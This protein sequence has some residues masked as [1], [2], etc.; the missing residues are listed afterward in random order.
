M[1]LSP[2]PEPAPSAFAKLAAQ[3]PL[4]A[5][6]AAPELKPT[7]KLTAFTQQQPILITYGARLHTHPCI[8]IATVVLPIAYRSRSRRQITATRWLQHSSVRL[9]SRLWLRKYGA[10]AQRSRRNARP[11]PRAQRLRT[12]L[13]VIPAER[14]AAVA[15]KSI[16]RC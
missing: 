7:V 2:A 6:S 4:A 12:L 15:R 1:T 5:Q 11:P 13:L 16:L 14:S 10:S 9:S 3:S 8:L